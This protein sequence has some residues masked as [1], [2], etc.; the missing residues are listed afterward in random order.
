VNPVVEI[1]HRIPKP[2]IFIGFVAPVGADLDSVVS[3]FSTF[4]QEAMK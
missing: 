4:A 2:E 1:L 3:A